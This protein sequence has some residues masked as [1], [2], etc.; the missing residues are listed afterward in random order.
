MD[1]KVYTTDI[2]PY[3]K[4]QELNVL[5]QKLPLELHT[6]AQ[7]YR[8]ESDAYAFILGRLLLKTGLESLGLGHLFDKIR[9][10]KNGKPFIE[11]L[12]FNISH[13]ENKV[14]CAL[15][16]KGEIGIDIE[17]IKPIDLQNFVAFFTKKE[18]QLIQTASEP[19]QD[20]YRIWTRKESIIK[21]LGANLA[22]LH[23]IEIDQHVDVYYENE[24][25]WYM[26]DL[27]LGNG[28]TSAVCTEFECM[29]HSIV[30]VS[31]FQ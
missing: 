19:L 2:E 25:Q 1:I 14:M 17:K 23:Q 4:V 22:Y 5:L 20:F 21:A 26:Q 13:T 3:Q 12:F 15:S 27:D 10:A 9:I 16:T 30:S 29:E 18:M 31:T 7:R 6:R 11:G 8:F 28:Y 24:R